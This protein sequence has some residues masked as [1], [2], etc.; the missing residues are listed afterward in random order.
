MQLALKVPSRVHCNPG[1]GDWTGQ[2]AS[3]VPFGD[4]LTETGE[5]GSFGDTLTE[6]GAVSLM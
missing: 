6:T 2:L 5:Y 4:T 1:S 3:V